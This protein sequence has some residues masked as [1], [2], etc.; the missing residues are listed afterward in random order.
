MTTP[1][2][3]A[4]NALLCDAAQAVGDKLYILGGGWSYVWPAQPRAPVM[5]AIAVH[6][7]IPWSMANQRL[8]LDAR[9]VTEDGEQV[10]QEFGEVRAQG[11]IEA[12]R[13][14]GVRQGAPL[15]VPFAIQFPALQLDYGGYAWEIEVN[16]RVL[17]RLPFQVAEPP[18]AAAR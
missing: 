18:T 10:S 16:G 1:E 14:P 9:L 15:A 5:I 3:L 12:G 2:Q 13:P 4:V 17:S 11:Q 7:S 8:N 6:L